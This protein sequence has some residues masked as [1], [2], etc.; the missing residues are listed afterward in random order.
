LA[1][2]SGNPAQAQ[3]QTR[4][5]LFDFDSPNLL[6]DSG[7][8]PLQMLGVTQAVSWSSNCMVAMGTNTFQL[9]YADVEQ[10]GTTNINFDIGTVRFWF[11]PMRGGQEPVVAT[12]FGVGNRDNDDYWYLLSLLR[13]GPAGH[14]H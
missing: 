12:L 7:Q 14:L 6:G 1:L 5:A 11:R 2:W 10:D 3:A 8:A 4:L 9:R 13:G